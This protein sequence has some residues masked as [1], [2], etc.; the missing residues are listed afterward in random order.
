MVMFC[1]KLSLPTLPL[2]VL[3]ALL[4]N[5]VWT[6]IGVVDNLMSLGLESLH[7]IYWKVTDINTLSKGKIT[8]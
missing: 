5:F 8:L 3:Y 6:K 2:L 4:R 7:E 1:W